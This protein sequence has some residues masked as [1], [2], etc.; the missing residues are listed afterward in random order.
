M[1]SATISPRLL[2]TACRAQHQARMN[3]ANLY[4]SCI[5]SSQSCRQPE[6]V[7]QKC[8][9][10]HPPKQASCSQNKFCHAFQLMHRATSVILVVPEPMQASCS[11]NNR[12]HAFQIV[13]HATGVILVVPDPMQALKMLASLCMNSLQTLH[14]GQTHIPNNP[15]SSSHITRHARFRR[16]RARVAGTVA[17]IMLNGE[18]VG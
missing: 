2:H 3:G 10:P 5:I 13:H 15:V 7:S 8:L 9:R 12:C 18:V 1:R 16:P 11:Q 6:N 14:L 17:A 4:A